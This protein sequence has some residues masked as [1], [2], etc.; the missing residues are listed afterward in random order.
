VCAKFNEADI[1]AR[2][3]RGALDTIEE[4]SNPEAWLPIGTRSIMTTFRFR[5]G[6][7]IALTHHYLP[8]AGTPVRHP[9]PQFS[10]AVRSPHNPKWILVVNERWVPAHTN[11][12]HCA[13]CG[14]W[15]SRAQASL[16]K[17]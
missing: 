11:K 12:G 15:M 10:D 4:D 7:V 3:R 6:P 8:P 1:V 13:D 17:A 5:N 9:F 14:E 16:E 2:A